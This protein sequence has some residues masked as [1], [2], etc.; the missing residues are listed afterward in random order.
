MDFETVK[1]FG[2]FLP[3]LSRF[4]LAYCNAVVRGQTFNLCELSILVNRGG[5]RVPTWMNRNLDRNPDALKLFDSLLPITS[6]LLFDHR[7]HLRRQLLQARVVPRTKA[8]VLATFL[9]SSVC[10]TAESLVLHAGLTRKTARAWL[11]KAEQSGLLQIFSTGHEVFYLNLE[12]LC[13][14]AEGQLIHPGFRAARISEMRDLRSRRDW[15]NNSRL[16][17]KFPD[18]YR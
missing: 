12:L 2:V 8:P 18:F 9:A 17:V 6:Q 7:Q 16:A 4:R 14:V 1:E 5:R 15:L 13:I 3:R 11:S 10:A